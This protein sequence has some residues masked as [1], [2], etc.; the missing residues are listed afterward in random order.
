[1]C[2]PSLM[3]IRTGAWEGVVHPLGKKTAMYRHLPAMPF[4]DSY[5]AVTQHTQAVR[6]LYCEEW[7]SLDQLDDGIWIS[8]GRLKLPFESPHIVLALIAATHR[9]E[10]R[11]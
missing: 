2:G 4:S 7:P 6:R 11:L 10:F 9:I 8:C 1:M 5:Q 3:R